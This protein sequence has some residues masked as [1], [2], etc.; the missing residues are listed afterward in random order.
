MWGTGAY[1]AAQTLAPVAE[2]TM[3]SRNDGTAIVAVVPWA[4]FAWSWTMPHCTGSTAG[5]CAE[6]EPLPSVVTPAPGI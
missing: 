3:A 1:G 6:K 2:L 5:T 4:S